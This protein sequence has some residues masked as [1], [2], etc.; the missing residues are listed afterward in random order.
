VSRW[1]GNELFGSV[2]GALSCQGVSDR[3]QRVLGLEE[4]ALGASEGDEMKKILLTATALATFA[5]AQSFA[6]EGTYVKGAVGYGMMDE[7]DVVRPLATGEIDPEGNA[8]F[9]LGLG[10]AFPNNWRV[11]LDIMD[12]YADGGAVD[13]VSGSTDIQNVTVMLNAIYDL[14]RAGRF[15]PYLGLGIGA[16]RTDTGIATSFGGPTVV[17]EDESTELGYQGLAGLGVKLSPRLSADFEYRYVEL[18]DVDGSSYAFEDNQSHDFLIGLRYALT[19]AAPAPA[20]APAPA[21]APPTAA[22]APAAAPACEN[23]DFIVYFEFDESDLTTQAADTIGAAAQRSA[24][25]SVTRV[26]IEG[27]ADRSGSPAYNTA[28][29]ERRARSVSAELVRRGIPASAITIEALGESAPAVDT[30]DGARE[31]LNRRSEV[32]IVV[33]GPGA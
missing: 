14:N 21:P 6:Q 24:N 8:R 33:A 17:E 32:V 5:A 23:V 27:H 15:N 10:H 28:L 25:C 22:R 12:R 26:N 19:G 4:L 29:S 2:F 3:A 18:G 20:R 16:S 13:D 9:M 11:D 7:S 1:D 30:P 31:P